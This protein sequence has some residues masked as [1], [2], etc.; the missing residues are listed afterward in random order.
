MQDGS[1]TVPYTAQQVGINPLIDIT[2]SNGTT[3][4][5]LLAPAAS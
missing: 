1:E 4:G 2:C 5:T 3:L